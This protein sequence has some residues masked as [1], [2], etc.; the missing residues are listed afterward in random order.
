MHTE[1]QAQHGYQDEGDE[2]LHTHIALTFRFERA[3][4]RMPFANRLDDPLKHFIHY[5]TRATL[6][7][8]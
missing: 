2:C 3:L 8:F 1:D 6:E 4:E 5:V 7:G